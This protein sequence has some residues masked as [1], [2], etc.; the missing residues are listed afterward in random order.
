MAKPPVARLFAW[1]HVRV[2]VFGCFDKICYRSGNHCMSLTVKND[3]WS[4][5]KNESFK[6]RSRFGH[7]L[8]I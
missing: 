2:E 5:C 4:L 8:G 6:M 3:F 7:S 1:V